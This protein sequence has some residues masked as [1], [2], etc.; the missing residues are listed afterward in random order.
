MCDPVVPMTFDKA[1]TKCFCFESMAQIGC[2]SFPTSNF[3]FSF[4]TENIPKFKR[5][6]NDKKRGTNCMR[7]AAVSDVSVNESGAFLGN[8][9]QISM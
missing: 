4:Y 9:G 6:A 7:C 5:N 3:S 2:N 8:M 1:R